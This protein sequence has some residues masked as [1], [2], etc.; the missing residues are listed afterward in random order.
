MFSLKNVMR[1]NSASCLIF[2]GLFALYPADVA[3]FLSSSSPAPRMLIFM[4][5]LILVANGLHLLWASHYRLQN[6]KLI[7][8]FS[9][10]DF[11]WV[12]SSVAFIFSGLW[13]TSTEGILAST[14]VAVLVG[15]FGAFQMGARNNILARQS[16][17]RL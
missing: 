10:G 4:V 13:I 5:G 12:I 2:G 11:V 9:I 8:Y 3:S 6:L 14:V 7:L 17:I 15:L 16:D 1:S